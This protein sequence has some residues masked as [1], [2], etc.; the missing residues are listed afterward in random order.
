V[1]CHNPEQASRDQQVRDNLIAHLEELI[2][3]SDTWSARRRDELVGALRTKP[4]LRRYLR[5]TPT[6][7]LRIDRGAAKREA[8]LDGKWLLRTSDLTLSA[9]D[10]AAAYKQLIAVEAGW[11]D[12]KS[13][14]GLRPV[15]HRRE[16]RIRGH[17]QLCWLALLLIRVAENTTSQTWRSLRH[18]LDR[19]ALVTLATSHGTIAQRSQTT[20]AQRTVL[21]ALRLPE[22][23]KFFDFTPAPTDRPQPNPVDTHPDPPLTTYSHVSSPFLRHAHLPAAELRSA[24]GSR[25]CG[26]GTCRRIRQ[27]GP[28]MRRVRSPSVISGFPTSWYPWGSGRCAPLSSC[29][30]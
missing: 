25:S 11:R 29:R 30:C 27:D 14:R 21:N 2:N 19:M 7:L 22:P 10:L 9:E 16:D 6:G 26:R 12:M 23:P 5:R 18:E 4:G 20:P 13:S 3:G 1:I 17:I 24:G 15:H 8:H 28:V